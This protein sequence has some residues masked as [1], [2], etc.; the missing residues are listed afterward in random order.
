MTYRHGGSIVAICACFHFSSVAHA[1]P[2]SHDDAVRIALERA[3]ML[4]AQARRLDAA[5][6]AVTSAGRL[7]DPELIFGIENLPIEGPD[8]YSIGSDFMTMRRIG[9]MQPL[10][11]G[12]KRE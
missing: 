2:V 9:V 11:N 8:A 5:H 10:P 3:P 4:K 6:Q 7:P 12:A 1:E